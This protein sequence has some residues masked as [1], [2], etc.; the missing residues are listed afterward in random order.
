MNDEKLTWTV[1]L[2]DERPSRV[3]GIFAAA[4]FAFLLGFFAFRQP[5]L[6]LLG[7]MM[8]LGATADFWLGSRFSL[9]AKGATARTGASV[10]AMEWGEVRRVLERGREV[11]LSPL[12]SP[13]KLD[14]FRG[15]GLVTTEENRERV[16]EF[17][18]ARVAAAPSP[19]DSE[20][21]GE[22]TKEAT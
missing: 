5:V 10:T 12:E 2:A 16:L 3:Y 14:D 8:I 18:R 22:A 15:V 7:A 4:L 13:S 11:R 21:H 17:V 19:P 1:R 9:D 6:G 20:T